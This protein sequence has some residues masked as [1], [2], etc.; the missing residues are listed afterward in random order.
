MNKGVC[1]PGRSTEGA[2]LL[3]Q[4]LRNGLRSRTY[5]EG[6]VSAIKTQAY[7]IIW[8]MNMAWDVMLFELMHLAFNLEEV[9]LNQRFKCNFNLSPFKCHKCVFIY[10]ACIDGLSCM[11]IVQMDR[12]NFSDNF[13][14]INYFNLS[15]GWISMIFWSLNHF[16]EFPDLI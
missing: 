2:L 14:Y 12:L 8:C 15:Y 5:R 13:S 7:A 4:I 9:H 10:T 1:L 16:L 3:R 6:T 11:K